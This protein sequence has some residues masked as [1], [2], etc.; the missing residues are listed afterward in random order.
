MVLNQ[1]QNVDNKMHFWTISQSGCTEKH[2]VC[3]SQK[4]SSKETT[5]HNTECG[6]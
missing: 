3:Y 4:C 6:I 1:N 5:C 2:A